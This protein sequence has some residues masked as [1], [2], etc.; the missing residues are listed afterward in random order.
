MELEVIACPEHL[1]E[2]IAIPGHVAIS[3]EDYQSLFKINFPNLIIINDQVYRAFSDSRIDVGSIAM[4]SITRINTRALIRQLISVE[5]YD[6]SRAQATRKMTLEVDFLNRRHAT[7]DEFPFEYIVDG[8]KKYFLHRI[9]TKNQKFIVELDKVR[10]IVT[11]L[12]ITNGDS[13]KLCYEHTIIDIRSKS[14][15]ILEKNI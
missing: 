1:T 15:K 7:S 14:V 2:S 9:I 13:E 8:M 4:N 10:F 3:I 6:I 11:V 5:P 12:E